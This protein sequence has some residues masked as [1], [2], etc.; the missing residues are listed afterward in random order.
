MQETRTLGLLTR[1][2]FR[3]SF[4]VGDVIPFARRSGS[5]TVVAFTD[6][7]MKVKSSQRTDGYVLDFEKLGVVVEDFGSIAVEA[8]HDGVGDRLRERGLS[9]TST[10]AVLYAVAKEFLARSTVLKSSRASY[11]ADAVTE[12]MNLVADHSDTKPDDF[13]SAA[14]ARTLAGVEW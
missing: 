6:R 14:A 7:A 4:K 3:G 9:E 11:D 1:E 8:I 10:E 12:A 2:A 5:Y 13:L